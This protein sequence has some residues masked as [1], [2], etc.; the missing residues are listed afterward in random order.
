MD[1]ISIRPLSGHSQGF[2]AFFT[3]RNCHALLSTSLF[4]HVHMTSLK[5]SIHGALYRQQ[6][7]GNLEQEIAQVYRVDMSLARLEVHDGDIY[8]DL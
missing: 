3:Y 4:A 1:R 7:T 5:E 8:P 2:A 6:A